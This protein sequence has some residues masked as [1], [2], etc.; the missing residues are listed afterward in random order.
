MSNFDIENYGNFSSWKKIGRFKISVALNKDI[1]KDYT[2]VDISFVTKGNLNKN[3]FEYSSALVKPFLVFPRDDKR[4]WD[5]IKRI[6]DIC[7]A[8]QVLAEKENPTK[9]EEAF[10]TK[11]IEEIFLSGKSDFGRSSIKEFHEEMQ[12]YVSKEELEE[13]IKEG[14]EIEKRI[15]EQRKETSKQRIK[16]FEDAFN[17]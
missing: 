3:N 5:T 12:K 15:V 1:Q 4:D 16:D 13:K 10:K 8:Y 6:I 2:M 11:I 14:N 9:D 17:K 7:G